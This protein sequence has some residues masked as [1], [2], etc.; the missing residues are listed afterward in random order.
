[1]N[2]CHGSQCEHGINHIFSLILF[3]IRT[4]HSSF[5]T[6]ESTWTL[7]V[8][9]VRL[10]VKRYSSLDKVS[11]FV[12][13][14]RQSFVCIGKLQQRTNHKLLYWVAVEYLPLSVLLENGKIDLQ[15]ALHL[16]HSWFPKCLFWSL[17]F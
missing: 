13:I 11:G 16:V 6:A 10:A 4:I 15:L 8:V 2:S 12:G 5:C 1:M 17:Y 3:D 9:F 14:F 7:P